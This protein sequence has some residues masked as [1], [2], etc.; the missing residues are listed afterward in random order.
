[1]VKVQYYMKGKVQFYILELLPK[2]D[3]QFSTTK[4]DN[5]GHLTIKTGQALPLEWSQG[6]FIFLKI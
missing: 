2:S 5:K 3:F 4:P 1:M 6:G